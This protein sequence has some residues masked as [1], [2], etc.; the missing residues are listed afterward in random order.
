MPGKGSRRRITDE[1]SFRE[2]FTEIF[3]KKTEDEED[4]FEPST[5]DFEEGGDYD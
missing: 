1:K 3:I 4:I 5:P 2:N